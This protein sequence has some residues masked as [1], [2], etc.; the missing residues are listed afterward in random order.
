MTRPAYV[1]VPGGKASGS[2]PA[3]RAPESRDPAGEGSIDAASRLADIVGADRDDLSIELLFH[4]DFSV[5]A[6]L[7]ASNFDDIDIRKIEELLTPGGT[8]RSV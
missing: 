7:R 4:E 5:A 6:L 3:G 2:E 1:L 8:G